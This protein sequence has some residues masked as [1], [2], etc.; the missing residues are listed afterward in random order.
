MGQVSAFDIP[1]IGL[2]LE[3]TGADRIVDTIEKDLA[4]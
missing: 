1:F 4:C 2:R 3:M